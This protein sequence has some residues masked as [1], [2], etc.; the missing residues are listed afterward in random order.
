MECM[1][2]VYIIQRVSDNEV[3]DVLTN[4]NEVSEYCDSIEVSG[5][6]VYVTEHVTDSYAFF[7]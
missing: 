4:E 1:S 7:A 2:K 6:L 5:T 3:L